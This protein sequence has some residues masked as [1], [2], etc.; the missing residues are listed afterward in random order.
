M[1]LDPKIWGPH[2]WF[3]L[4]TIALS[5]PETPNDVVKKKYYDFIQ[6]LPLFIPVEEIGNT[7]SSF[8]DRYPV[9]PYLDSRQS[10]I[11]WMHFIHNKI[12]QSLGVDEKSITDSMT[13][14]YENYKPKI[15]KNQEQ[16]NRR[17]K[18]IFIATIIILS[19]IF[20]YLY[21]K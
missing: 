6:N 3:V 7:F 17:E 20:G 15:V 13:E 21:T 11:R 9:T 18:T 10:F 19:T 2:Y 4:H 14:Y 1:A 16:R 8:L 12:N 5:Y